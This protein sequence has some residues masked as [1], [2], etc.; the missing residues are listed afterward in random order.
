MR[1]RVLTR[2]AFC[3]FIPGEYLLVR[4]AMKPQLRFYAT[5][6]LHASEVSGGEAS[7]DDEQ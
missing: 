3:C 2:V 4:D 1:V 6:G 7:D 5:D